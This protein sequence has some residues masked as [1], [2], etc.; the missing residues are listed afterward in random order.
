MFEPD[1]VGV[2]D[3]LC[4]PDVVRTPDRLC[5]LETLS[6]AVGVLHVDGEIKVTPDAT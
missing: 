5:V 2:A 6:E 4:V 3:V 1:I